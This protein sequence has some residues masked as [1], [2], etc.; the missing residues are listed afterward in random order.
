[1]LLRNHHLVIPLLHRSISISLSTYLSLARSPALRALIAQFPIITTFF[2]PEAPIPISQ[3]WFVR[4]QSVQ[5]R[6]TRR[7]PNSVRPLRLNPTSSSLP[8]TTTPP[9]ATASP[10]PQT[11]LTLLRQLWPFN[12]ALGSGAYVPSFVKRPAIASTSLAHPR[13]PSALINCF[14]A[15]PDLSRRGTP[16]A[17]IS[18][19]DRSALRFPVLALATQQAGHHRSSASCQLRVSWA[20]TL[21]GNRNPRLQFAGLLYHPRSRLAL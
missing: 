10:S 19:T 5:A 15:R 18:R 7:E 20:P 8:P 9:P 17:W 21:S 4:P 2:Q 11:L 1:M 6:L 13:Q 16:S 3:R 12:S 14:V